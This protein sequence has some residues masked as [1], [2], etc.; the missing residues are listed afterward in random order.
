MS[1]HQP[2]RVAAI[3]S[4]PLANSL[5]SGII[6]RPYWKSRMWKISLQ[7]EKSL[8]KP[9]AVVLT[10]KANEVPILVKFWLIMTI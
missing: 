2:S 8:T 6:L 7:V 4:S 9:N 5:H 10:K 3:G 1:I